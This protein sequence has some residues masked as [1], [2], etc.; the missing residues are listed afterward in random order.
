VRADADEARM[1]NAFSMMSFMLPG[2]LLGGAAAFGGVG[3]LLRRVQ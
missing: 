2:V 3:S 1:Y